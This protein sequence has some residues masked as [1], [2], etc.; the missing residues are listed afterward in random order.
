MKNKIILGID[1]GGTHTDAVV[2]NSVSQQILVSTK[3]ETNHNDLSLS[4]SRIFDDIGHLNWAGGLQAIDQIHLSTTLA[5]N[6]ITEGQSTRVGLILI[7]Y[8]EEHALVGEM[9]NRLP[10]AKLFFVAGG[11]DYYG[12]EVVPLNEE[13]LLQGIDRLKGK[14]SGW[15][16]S[17][18]FSVKNPA[19]EIRAEELIRSI[20]TKPV[21]LGRDL[22]GQ[23]DALRRAATAAL[24]AGLVII[25]NRLL[26]AVKLSAKRSGLSRARL[27][28]VKGD[29]SLVSED[30]ARKKPIET[31]VSGPAASLVG[32]KVL[33][34]GFLSPEEKNLWVVDVGGTTTDMALV[35]DGL[36]AVNANGAKIGQWETMTV[37][38]ETSTIGLGG[39]SLTRL[40]N[41]GLVIMGPRR[42]LPLCRLARQSP[43]ILKILQVQCY[44]RTPLSQAGCFF[45]PG[46]PPDGD[47]GPDEQLLINALTDQSPLALSSYLRIIAQ[48][49]EQFK[50]LDS[51]H[52][53]SI[54]ISAFTPTDA[55]SILGLYKEGTQEAAILGAEIIGRRLKKSAKQVARMILDEFGRKLAQEIISYGFHRDG[56][57]FNPKEF[58]T[59]GILGGTLGRRPH[60]NMQITVRSLDTVV[61]LGAPVNTLLPFLSKYLAGRI[62]VP[63]CYDAASAAGAAASP[64]YLSRQVE[65]HNLPSFSGFRLFLPDEMVDG[66]SVDELVGI[67]EM[68]M[69]KYM[70]NL[71][72][73]AGAT[74]PITTISRDDRKLSMGED[75]MHLGTTLT[76]TV[77]EST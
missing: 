9:A 45:F 70:R 8:D 44:E 34:D 26:D 35:K 47:L 51:L 50:G 20:S 29:G 41:D 57:T 32:A 12:Q 10:L 42:V 28:V 13:A 33:V 64:I 72:H 49:G 53:P 39:D 21:T 68:R 52:H 5:T 59:E 77:K 71:A 24:N 7:G 75:T 48:A 3:T 76:L 73:L 36:P 11:H 6:A 23:L 63:P 74:N 65:I 61:L 58:T 56:L 38:V 2:Y 18:M 55:M 43:Q 27:M 16:V 22:T 14:V 17:S 62:L 60:G 15:A 54:M 25:I 66:D 37:A 40:D 19:H 4:I 30:W 67:A 31:V 69:G 1:T 46:L